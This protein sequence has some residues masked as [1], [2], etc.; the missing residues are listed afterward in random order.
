MIFTGL[1]TWTSK[2]LTAR[3]KLW[4]SMRVNLKVI[5]CQLMKPNLEIV[6]D[7]E[8]EG[9]VDLVEGVVEGVVDLVEGIVAGE[10]EVDLVE[11]IVA[12][13][14]EVDLVEGM[15]AEDSTNQALLHQV[16]CFFS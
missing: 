8:V 10:E 14:E 1:H 11:G 15:V 4:N 12:V 6:R 7:P 13:E 3:T 2:I 5:L 9:V 16:R